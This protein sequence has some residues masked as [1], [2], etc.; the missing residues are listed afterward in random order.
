[1]YAFSNGVPEDLEQLLAHAGIQNFLD[2]TVSVDPKQTFKQNPVVYQ[3]FL[4]STGSSLDDTWLISSNGFD[5]CGAL[6]FGMRA[7]WLQRNA[8]V[9]FDHWE[10][11]SNRNR[12]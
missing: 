11:A 4:D 10:W 1:M 5:V 6:A 12:S 7:L 2:G 9:I 8:A 3:H